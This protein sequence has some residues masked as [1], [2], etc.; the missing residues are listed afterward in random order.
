MTYLFLLRCHVHANLGGHVRVKL[1]RHVGV[2]QRTDWFWQFNFTL[3]NLQIELLLQSLDDLF[4]W[5]GPKQPTIFAGLGYDF[6]N[7]LVVFQVLLQFLGF[8]LVFSLT[9]FLCLAFTL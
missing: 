3:I 4:A 9:P 7:R 2:A 1:D 6:D 8:G 5:N